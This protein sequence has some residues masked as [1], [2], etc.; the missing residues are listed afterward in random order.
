[1]RESTIIVWTDEGT[2]SDL[3]SARTEQPEVVYSCNC[4]NCANK[5]D[6][7]D[8]VGGIIILLFFIVLLPIAI[9]AAR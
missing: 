9:W 2:L 4:A 5:D 6:V 3:D 8:V 1:M 7:D